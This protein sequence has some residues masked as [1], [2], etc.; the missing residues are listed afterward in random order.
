MKVRN[1]SYVTH[2]NIAMERAVEFG[3]NGLVNEYLVTL[4]GRCTEVYLICWNE[5]LHAA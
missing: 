3:C 2:K 5:L 4:F 1:K